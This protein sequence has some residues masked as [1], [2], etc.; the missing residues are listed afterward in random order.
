MCVHTHTHVCVSIYI[1]GRDLWGIQ[2]MLETSNSTSERAA[3]LEAERL[4][5]PTDDKTR[6]QRAIMHGDVGELRNAFTLPG[7]SKEDKRMG[8]HVARLIAQ[9]HEHELK[10]AGLSKY[11]ANTRR[12]ASTQALRMR[13]NPMPACV[14]TAQMFLVSTF[15]KVASNGRIVALYGKCTRILT[16]E[17]SC[18]DNC[19]VCMCGFRACANLPTRD[20]QDE[21]D[22][23]THKHDMGAAF[24]G[25]KT[26][27]VN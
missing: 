20:L 10:V 26:Q 21:N 3:A 8:S 18:Q 2:K 1:G 22:V 7:I 27:N 5:L 6:F 11:H 13:R 16:S 17:N 24:Y 12:A 9:G 15:S 23:D 19:G 14:C 4:G 25:H